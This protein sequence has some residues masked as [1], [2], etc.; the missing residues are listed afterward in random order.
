MTTLALETINGSPLLV[1]KGER[2]EV[3]QV[4]P[5]LRHHAFMR[6]GHWFVENG[7]SGFLHFM[8]IHITN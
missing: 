5:E 8:S 2:C 4:T 1:V 3:Y 7:G 6:S